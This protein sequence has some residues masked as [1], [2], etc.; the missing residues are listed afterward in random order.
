M[1]NTVYDSN[2]AA[3]LFQGELFYFFVTINQLY[4]W[5]VMTLSWTSDPLLT[6]VIM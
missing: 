6:E 1:V 3:K 2:P 4:K 5:Q